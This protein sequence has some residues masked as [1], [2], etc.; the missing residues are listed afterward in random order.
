VTLKEKEPV[1]SADL[2]CNMLVTDRP[3]EISC[4]LMM[5]LLW[6]HTVL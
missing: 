4:V 6:E 1:V 2:I 5:Q 3:S